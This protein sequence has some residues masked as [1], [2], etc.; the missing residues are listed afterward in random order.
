MPGQSVGF[1]ESALAASQIPDGDLDFA[2]WLQGL[3]MFDGGQLDRCLILDTL[4]YV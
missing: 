2:S 3:M 4:G 1:Q